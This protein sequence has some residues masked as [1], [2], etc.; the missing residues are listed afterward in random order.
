MP[1]ERKIIYSL[2]DIETVTLDNFR[3]VAKKF[4][5]DEFDIRQKVAKVQRHFMRTLQTMSNTEK[6][7]FLQPIL[8]PT[9]NNEYAR[10]IKLFNLLRIR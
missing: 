1:S 10:L 4:A 5:L 7:T 2:L 6:E 8:L 3:I 9:D